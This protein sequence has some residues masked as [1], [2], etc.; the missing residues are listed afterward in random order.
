MVDTY[1]HKLENPLDVDLMLFIGPLGMSGLT[2]YSSFYGIGKPVKGETIFI[3]VAL[4]A[5]GQMVGQLTKH[6]GLTVIGS[7]GCQEKLDFIVKELRFDGGFNYKTE[8]PIWM[9]SCD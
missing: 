2:A 8:K 6:D 5:V 4:G 3:S 7:V 1:I 9:W